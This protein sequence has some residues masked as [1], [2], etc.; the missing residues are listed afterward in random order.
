METRTLVQV[1]LK[2]AAVSISPNMHF[3][4]GVGVMYNDC[5]VNFMCVFIA[6]NT[7]FLRI[8]THEGLT[9]D[10]PENAWEGKTIDFHLVVNDVTQKS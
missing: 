3:P 10:V 8:I 2:D 5:N 7:R 4:N 1:P 6:S 9:F